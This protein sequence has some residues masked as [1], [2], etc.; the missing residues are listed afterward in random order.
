MQER[1]VSIGGETH[2]LEPPFYVLATQ[3]PIEM[4]GTYPL[5]EAQMDRFLMKVEIPSPRGKDLVNILT[6]IDAFVEDPGLE[7]VATGEQVVEMGRVLR[8]VPIPETSAELA[9][10]IVEISH[11]THPEAPEDIR[12]F[13]RYGA[14]PR[15]GQAILLVA[16][17]RALLDGRFAVGP[18]DVSACALPCLR[19]RI[20]RSFE[21]EADDVPPDDLVRT[22]VQAA[23][24]PKPASLIP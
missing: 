17:L 21:G 7:A 20:L 11:P 3:N 14:S 1:T 13:V 10:R 4:E 9:A 23:G 15:G 22:V 5:P 2:V 8:Q 19:H 24:A 6:R 18:E 12:R 16:R